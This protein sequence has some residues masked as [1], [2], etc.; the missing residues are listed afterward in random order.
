M[1][2]CVTKGRYCLNRWISIFS[3]WIT[4]IKAKD[5]LDLIKSNILL[6]F[7]SVW[8]EILNVLSILKDKSLLRVKSKGYNIL[9]IAYC[10]LKNFLIL[11]FRSVHKLLVISY[12]ND[13][14]NIKS[15]L[16]PFVENKRN[17][18]THMHCFSWRSS[19]RI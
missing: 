15:I 4:I 7:D 1:R 2:E 3:Y 10:H 17:S 19:S 14:G 5:S 13:Q 11:K 16:H 18:M 6:N 9:Y 8:I 12:L